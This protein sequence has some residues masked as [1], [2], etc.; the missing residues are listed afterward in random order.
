MTRS[1][2]DRQGPERRAEGSQTLLVF[3]AETL[4]LFRLDAEHFFLSRH[5]SF[6]SPFC[7]REQFAEFLFHGLRLRGQFGKVDVDNCDS[8]KHLKNG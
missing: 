6:K 5:L 1:A 7:L 8:R 2:R 4:L 3:A